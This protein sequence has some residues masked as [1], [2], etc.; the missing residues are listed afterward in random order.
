MRIPGKKLKSTLECV[1]SYHRIE[2]EEAD[3]H[4]TT[5]ATEWGNSVTEGFLSSGDS[6]IKHTDMIIDDCP[7]TTPDRDFEKIADNII[8]YYFV[9]LFC[10]K[11]TRIDWCLMQ[12]S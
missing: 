5:F 9:L 3:R 8:T 1:D 11:A 7:S 2:L 6:Y 10:P 4:K 12:R